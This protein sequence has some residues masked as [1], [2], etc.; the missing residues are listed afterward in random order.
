MDESQTEKDEYEKILQNENLLE[1]FHVFSKDD[2]MSQGKFL[3]IFKNSKLV[4]KKLLTTTRV[5][6]IFNNIKTKGKQKISYQ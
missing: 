5:D 1:L 2:E 6:I 4:D 3:Q